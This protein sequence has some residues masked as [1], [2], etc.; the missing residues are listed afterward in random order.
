M[1]EEG[2][3]V[4]V[5]YLM[6]KEVKNLTRC[7]EVAD[8]DRP[9]I[10]ILG[11]LKVSDKIQVI[12]TL[13]KKCDKILI[14]GA[15]AFTFKKALG[16]GI[17]NS[18]VEDEQLD[19][20]K[21]CLAEAK[22]KIVLPVDAI[23]TDSFEDKPGRKIMVVDLAKP[24]DKIPDGFQGVDVGPKTAKLFAEE[25]SKAHMVFWNGPMGV[26][27]QPEFQAGTKAVCEAIRD[28][29]GHA[30]TVCGG[31]DS[32][33]AVKQFGYKADFSHDSTGGGASLEMI[34]ND[35]H[36]PGVDVLK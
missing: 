11:G 7:V 20:A 26:F 10:A 24:G 32:A 3:P 25:I 18:P 35:G 6:I 12:D 36:L 8:T 33:S 29:K 23:V 1:K 14:G 9:Y 2:K 22:G 21:K 5:G 31:G 30:F 34:Q 19:Y 27:E 28:I 4:A 16:M 15:M 13:L 17:G